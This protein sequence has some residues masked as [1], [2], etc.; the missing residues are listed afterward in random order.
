MIGLRS[1]LDWGGDSSKDKGA[2]KKA[3]DWRVISLRVDRLLVR[4]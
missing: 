2:G 1:G 3:I 4:K